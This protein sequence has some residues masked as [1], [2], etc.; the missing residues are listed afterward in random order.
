MPKRSIAAFC[1]YMALA[2][3]G[4]DVLAQEPAACGLQRG[5]IVTAAD[6][7]GRDRLHVLI[8]ALGPQPVWAERVYAKK[9]LT[10]AP[11]NAGDLVFV[12][13]EGC[14]P[15]RPVVIGFARP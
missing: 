4:D 3:V 14:D 1:G 10:P 12:L 5:S 9:P 2:A 7:E 13:F 11:A 8:P 6:P 15:G